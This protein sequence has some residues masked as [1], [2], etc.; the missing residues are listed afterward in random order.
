MKIVWAGCQANACV[1]R[2][3]TRTCDDFRIYLSLRM[4]NV[5]THLAIHSQHR[6]VDVRFSS[7]NRQLR[8]CNEKDRCRNTYSGNLPLHRAIYSFL[9]LPAVNSSDS[10]CARFEERP[11]TMMPDVKRS[12]RF[13][14]GKRVVNTIELNA[15]GDS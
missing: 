8:E 1:S 12:R 6:F 11:T 13:T 7:T 9:T 5:E 14:A 4:D 2:S 3:S 10:V 15:C